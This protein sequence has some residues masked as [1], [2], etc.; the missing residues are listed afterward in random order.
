MVER[1]ANPIASG[2]PDST[3]AF[4]GR[5]VRLHNALS[6]A[7]VR[8][9]A[10]R[11]VSWVVEVDIRQYLGPCIGRE[12]LMRLETVSATTGTTSSTGAGVERRRLE[13]GGG[14]K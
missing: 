11:K 10:A 1:L 9:G 13:W 2:V 4:A 3:T 14:A 12:Q 6:H 7:G 5:G 8:G